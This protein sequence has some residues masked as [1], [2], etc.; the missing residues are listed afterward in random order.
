MDKAAGV[1]T[2][3]TEYSKSD[4]EVTE[5]VLR[6][7]V[8][9]TAIKAGKVNLN[10]SADFSVCNESACKLIRDEKLAWEVAVR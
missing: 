4:A 7:K 10:G 9:F 1:D 5:E 8:A 3:K 6:F 2:P